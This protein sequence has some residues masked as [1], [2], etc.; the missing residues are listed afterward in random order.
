[1][2]LFKEFIVEKNDHSIIPAL[3]RADKSWIFSGVDK[4]NL[5]AAEFATKGKLLNDWL[6]STALN[7]IMEKLML[8]SVLCQSGKGMLHMW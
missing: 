3:Q 5:L 4:S 2:A 7:G 1:M 6:M 8:L